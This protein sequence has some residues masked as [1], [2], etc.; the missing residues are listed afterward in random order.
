PC[1][2]H[3]DSIRWDLTSEQPG[4]DPPRPFSFRTAA[5]TQAQIS[6]WTCHTTPEAHAI[7]RANLHRAPMYNGRIASI[8]PRYCPSIEDKVVRFADKEQHHLFLEP[9]GR[10][11]KEIYVNGLSTSLPLDVQDAILAA[12]PALAGAHVLRHGYAVEYDVVAPDQMDHRLE[13]RRVAGLHFA[14]QINGTSGYEE[15]AAQGLIAGAS[16]ALWALGRPPL[17]IARD[18]GYI[19]VL[20]DDLVTQGC[21]EPYR[22]FTARA[23]YR[24]LLR[25]DNAEARLNDLAFATGLIDAERHARVQT[26]VAKITAMAA[27]IARR[28]D[29]GEA[30]AWLRERAEAQA[31]Y[32]DYLVRQQREVDRMRGD[33]SDLPIDPATDYHRLA[34]LTTEAAERLARVRPT[35]TGQVARIP[36]I[37]PAALMCVWA[38]ARAALR[39]AA[40][41]AAAT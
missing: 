4:D 2:L 11:T 26:R 18:Q 15:A 31:C 34:G 9:E 22:M 33:A 23:E 3:A 41:A 37:T 40:E 20:V 32:A 39:E 21:D 13:C 12:I 28:K 10:T 19:G 38:H 17:T 25:E 35:S 6:C 36:G 27:A 14:G 8:G 1:R 5:I 30:P 16:A 7:I 24:L 29:P